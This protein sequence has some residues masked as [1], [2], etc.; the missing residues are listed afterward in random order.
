M[1]S[2]LR[3]L[4]GLPQNSLKEVKEFIDALEKQTGKR[5]ET[6]HRELLQ[7]NKFLRSRNGWEDSKGWIFRKRTRRHLV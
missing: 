4:E 6:G 7:E 1:L 5:H 2:I 3:A